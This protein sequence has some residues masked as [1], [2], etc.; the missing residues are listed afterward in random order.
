M[1][2]ERKGTPRSGTAHLIIVVIEI[3]LLVSILVRVRVLQI[4]ETPLRQDKDEK[5]VS[6]R[7]TTTRKKEI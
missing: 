4:L 3:L 6:S 7:Q 5:A 2:N 1:H